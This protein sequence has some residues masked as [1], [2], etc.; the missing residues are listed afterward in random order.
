MSFMDSVKTFFGL[1]K[2]TKANIII[3]TKIST[4]AQLQKAAVEQRRKD[5]QKIE[6]ALNQ[7]KNS[8]DLN[9][10]YKQNEQLRL[11][12]LEAARHAAVDDYIRKTNK[13]NQQA[14]YILDEEHMKQCRAASIYNDD[15]MVS[16]NSSSSSNYSDSSSSSCS[17]SSSSSSSSSD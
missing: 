11:S 14:D 3:P 13:P 10:K 1:N 16:Y 7:K 12:L 15:S 4:P 2:P 6:R 9:L 8:E 5:L 17:S